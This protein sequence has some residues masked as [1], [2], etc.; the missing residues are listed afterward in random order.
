MLKKA[1]TEVYEFSVYEA[2]RLSY[3]TLKRG[4][5][6]AY[7]GRVIDDWCPP[8]WILNTV[9][10]ADGSESSHPVFFHLIWALNW[11]SYG[12]LV[13]E[14]H[15]ET[16]A[17]YVVNDVVQGTPT[18]YWPYK[19]TP[20]NKTVDGAGREHLLESQMLTRNGPSRTTYNWRGLLLLLSCC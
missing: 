13:D 19:C 2:L 4:T 6:T 16:N 11:V 7:T 12:F 3:S 5:T 17:L 20:A 10:L 9:H 15:A 1:P 18:L 14:R 8:H